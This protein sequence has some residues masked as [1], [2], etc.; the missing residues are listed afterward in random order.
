MPF[1]IYAEIKGNLILDV[2][3]HHRDAYL[4]Y[5][6][7]VSKLTKAAIK[8]WKANPDL[9]PQINEYSSDGF[10]KSF[11]CSCGYVFC[12]KIPEEVEINSYI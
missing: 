3:Q 4:E 7:I 6:R 11:E 9:L 8:R 12:E 10:D 5:H 1:T 2:Y